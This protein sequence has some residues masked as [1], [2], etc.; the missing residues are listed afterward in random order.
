LSCSDEIER[1]ATDACDNISVQESLSKNNE[2]KSLHNNAKLE[3]DLKDDEHVKQVP[4]GTSK[5]LPQSVDKVTTQTNVVLKDDLLASDIIYDSAFGDGVIYN[6][7]VLGQEND[8][9]STEFVIRID[10]EHARVLIDTGTKYCYTSEQFVNL[11]QAPIRHQTQKYRV[12]AAF[13][14]EVVDDRISLVNL[15]IVGIKIP[16]RTRI[17]PLDSYDIILGRNWIKKWVSSTC[18]QTNVWR[19]FNPGGGIREFCPASFEFPGESL[20]QLSG[21]IYDESK[22]SLTEFRRA[23]KDKDTE[24][25]MCMVNTDDIA[26]MNDEDL[27]ALMEE[28]LGPR[29]EDPDPLPTVVAPEGTDFRASLEGLVKKYQTSFSKVTKAASVTTSVEHLVDTGDAEPIGQRVRPMSPLLLQELKKKL[30]D[31]LKSG[32]IRPSSSPWSS[33]VLFAKKPGGGLRFCVDYRAVNEVTKRDRH[34]LPLAQECFDALHGAKISSKLDL[35]SGFHQLSIATA[36]IPKTAFGTKY[37][38]YEWLVMPFGLM[39]GPSSFQRLMTNILRDVIDVNVQVYLDDILIY[40]PSEAQHLKDLEKVL[41][42]LK[43]N[44]LKISGGKSTL[45]AVEIDYIGHVISSDGIRPMPSKIEDSR[46]WPRPSTVYDVRS[47]LG[48]TGYYRHY[49][50]NFAQT[51]AP[52]HDLTGG[53][54]TK[55]QSVTWLPVHKYAFEHLKEDL[56]TAPILLIPDPSKSYVMDTDAS[57]KALGGILQQLGPDNRLH[58]VA[59]ES[60]KFSPA[61]QNYPAQERELLAII[62][63]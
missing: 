43:E 45:G 27:L 61:Q 44:D 13:G 55:R 50:K 16:W 57:D 4:T 7:S 24:T 21:E 47:S 2:F 51:A 23:L 1:I 9:F 12:K 56:C 19:L 8:E 28:P 34:P 38:H 37:G 33:P 40:S 17:A 36:H 52:L 46:S 62:H 41:S 18:W 14:H 58:P 5:T 22:M 54:V 49:V 39:N 48:L 10:G 26:A 6:L 11:V 35:K 32:F 63:C 25:F 20:N 30:K 29:L 42:I 59:F 60:S 53:N 3:V 15:E 31:L